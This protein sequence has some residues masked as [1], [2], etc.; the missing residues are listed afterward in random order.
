[1][2]TRIAMSAA[3]LGV[4]LLAGCAG[5]HDRMHGM[6]HGDEWPATA[7]RL[8]SPGLPEGGIMDRKFAGDTKDNPNCVGQNISP[9]LE[10]KNA[11]AKTRSFAVIMADPAG[12]GG[13]GVLHWLAYGIPANV[14]SLAEGEAS[15]PSPKFTG[16]LNSR[17]TTV[18]AG[19]CTPKGIG[20]HHYLYTFIATDLEPGALAPGLTQ[21][22]LLAALKGHGLAATSLALRFVN[23]P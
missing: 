4:S 13:Q 18:Y 12:Q 19:P 3:A 6:V 11:P 14:T 23:R 10:W 21:E 2:D 15:A 1:M 16:G 17:K 20:P 22:Q 9:A 8:T 7:F 5:M